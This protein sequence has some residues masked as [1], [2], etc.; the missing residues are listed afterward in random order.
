MKIAFVATVAMVA[1][2]PARSHKLYVET[3]GLPLQAEGDGYF[4]SEK[5]AGCKSF[6][7]WPLSQAVASTSQP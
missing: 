2:D 6:G 1:P 4:H 5:I 7:I 3:I